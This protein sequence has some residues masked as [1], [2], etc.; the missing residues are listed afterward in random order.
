MAKNIHTTY[1]KDAGNWRNISEGA[2]K[3]SKVYDTKQE[4]QSSGRQSARNNHVEHL[5]HNQDGKIG[6]RNSYG[7]DPHPPKG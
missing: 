6:S 7:K 3:P 1:S 5:I 2:S 4:A